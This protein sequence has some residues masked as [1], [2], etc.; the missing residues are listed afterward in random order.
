MNRPKWVRI[1]RGQT[2][3]VRQAKDSRCS[4]RDY[5]GAGCG[6][7]DIAAPCS[8]GKADRLVRRELAARQDLRSAQPDAEPVRCNL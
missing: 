4:G 3:L 8:Q 6:A 2:R 7:W 1:F 5:A